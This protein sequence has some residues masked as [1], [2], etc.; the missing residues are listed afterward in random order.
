M[1]KIFLVFLS[2]FMGT[3]IYSGSKLMKAG[4]NSVVIVGKINIHVNE[5]NFAFYAKTWGV[6]DISKPSSYVIFDDGYKNYYRDDFMDKISK[7]ST[8]GFHIY[9]ENEYF[10]SKRSIKNNE[11]VSNSPVTWCFFS[12]KKFQIYFPLRF[13]TVVPKG[14]KYIYVGDFNYYLEGSD[15]SPVK[16][17]VS[18]NFD[19]AKEFIKQTYGDDVQLCRVEI[20]NLK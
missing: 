18:D 10:L 17:T 20:E 2:V 13:K 3:F 7:S 6:E 9:R 1:K 11:L 8:F 14:E 15:F 12:D 4:S 19:Q 16:I 5:E